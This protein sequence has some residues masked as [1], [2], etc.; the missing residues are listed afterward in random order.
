VQRERI[1]LEGG[2]EEEGVELWEKEASM[3]LEEEREIQP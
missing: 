3:D 2:Q 1:P